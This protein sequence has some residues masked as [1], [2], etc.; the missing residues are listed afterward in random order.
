MSTISVAP[1]HTVSVA[2]K[3]SEFG[4]A[5]FNESTSQVGFGSVAARPLWDLNSNSVPNFD[6]RSWRRQAYLASKRTMDFCISLSAF[7]ILSPVFLVAALAIFLYDGG[8][9]IFRQIRVGKDNRRFWCYKFRSMVRNAEQLKRQLEQQNDHSDPR[10]FKMKCDPR[11]TP[12]GRF[13]RRFSI[14]E[15]P[16]I[17]NVLV[18]DMSL[19]GPRPS[20]PCEVE[21]YS[22]E[23]MRRLAV[24]PGLT[25]IWQVSGRSNLPFPEQV[26]LDVQYIEQQSFLLDLKLIAKTLPAVVSGDGAL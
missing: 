7:L 25:C 10:T 23:D 8:S 2:P 9:P 15:L 26:K 3:D 16:Q 14:D 12:P 19:V 4:K 20:L 18:G 5:R 1:E 24:K 21:L 11:I 17:Y 6:T 13:I 22:N